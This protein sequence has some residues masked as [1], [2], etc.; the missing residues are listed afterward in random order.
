[1]L[2]SNWQIYLFNLYIPVTEAEIL[3][4]GELGGLGSDERE[5]IQ[6]NESD[7]K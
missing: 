4:G 7:F 5:E 6:L 2:Q 1:M 3:P